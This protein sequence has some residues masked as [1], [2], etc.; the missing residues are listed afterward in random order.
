MNN[1]LG[2]YQHF[3]IL[4]GYTKKPIGLNNLKSFI[5]KGCGIDGYFTAHIPVGMMQGLSRCYLP[6]AFFIQVQKWTTR[7][8][9]KNPGNILFSPGFKCLGNSTVL[10][11]N[12]Q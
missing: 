2:V 7:G 4:Q 5:H 6:K 3:N 1:G 8:C 12:R 9:K 10:T 11:V